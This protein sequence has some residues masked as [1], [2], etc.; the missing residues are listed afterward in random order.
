MHYRF[1]D[2]LGW[3]D[4]PFSVHLVS[5]EWRRTTLAMPDTGEL[6]NVLQI[7]L[8]DSRSGVLKARRAVG[9][10]APFTRTFETALRE[11]LEDGW[12]GK[13]AYDAALADVYKRHSSTAL[14]R[15]AVAH[16][17]VPGEVRCG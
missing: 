11:Q 1:G 5:P 9:L 7:H 13:M 12:C 3:S 17:R 6:R 15:R 14:A 10:S 2:Q 4:A 8:V 16:V